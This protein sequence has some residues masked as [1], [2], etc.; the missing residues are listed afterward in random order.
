MKPDQAT[1]A[2][3]AEIV[4]D[5]RIIVP[6]EGVV[7]AVNSMRAF[8]TDGL[9]ATY[10]LWDGPPLTVHH[11]GEAFEL[12][13]ADDKEVVR[14]VTPVPHKPRPTQPPICGPV[15]QGPPCPPVT[16]ACPRPTIACFGPADPTQ[17]GAG[18]PSP[19]GYGFPY[20]A[21]PYGAYQSPDPWAAYYGYGEQWAG[22]VD[23]SGVG[24]GYP[25]GT[26]DPQSGSYGT[27]GSD[28]SGSGQ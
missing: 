12:G 4:A 9:T 15:T 21:T 1:L 24:G 17:G 18:Q 11:E 10:R 6:G 22:G 2:R 27:G 23:P 5:M 13:G 20:G 14:A 7:D 16:L 25:A 28:P 19:Y 26:Y 8:E 3:R